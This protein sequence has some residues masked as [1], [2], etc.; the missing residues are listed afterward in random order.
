MQDFAEYLS[1]EAI[2]PEAVFHNFR[3][4]YFANKKAIFAFFEG[5]DDKKCY[6]TF[7]ERHFNFATMQYPFVCNGK[8]NIL[9]IYEMF[10]NSGFSETR[11]LFFIDK[12]HD[13]IVDRPLPQSIN[14]FVTDVYSIEN[15]LVSEHSVRILWCQ[16]EVEGRPDDVL[17]QI[18]ERFRQER[19]RFVRLM[20][21][22]MAWVIQK[23]KMGIAVDFSRVSMSQCFHIAQGVRKKPGALK[24][25]RQ[26]CEDDGSPIDL[27]SVKKLCEKLSI[28]DYQIW[29]RGKFE[30][31]FFEEF[32]TH[33]WKKLR[34]S[35]RASNKRVRRVKLPAGLAG[36]DLFETLSPRIQEPRRLLAFL[37]RFGSG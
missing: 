23:R 26:C 13:D 36:R 25:L 8:E 28:E 16:F 35:R 15:Y 4:E 17:S 12:D 7:L 14:V 2:S 10:V 9:K 32:L 29:L 11:V 22:Y 19:D 34:S 21:P 30:L 6:L 20:R 33:E 1:T 24:R 37:S 31:W 3:I 18:T 27:N 5:L